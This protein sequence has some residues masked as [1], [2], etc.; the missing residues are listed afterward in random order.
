MKPV[1]VILLVLGSLIALAGV[2]FHR[3]GASLGWATGTQRDDAGL[4]FTSASAFRI[5]WCTSRGAP[6]VAMVIT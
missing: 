4:A 1:R 6:S 3:S 2:R 5:R